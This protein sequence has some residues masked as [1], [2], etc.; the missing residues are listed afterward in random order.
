MQGL[1][2]VTMHEVGHTLGLRHNFKASAYLSLDDIDNDAEKNRGNRPDGLGDGLCPGA[3]C[4]QG[5]KAGRLLLDA[6]LARTTCGRS[7]TA[8]SRFGGSPDGE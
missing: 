1:K 8:T 7:N 2:E 5:E 6:R 3:H 4:S